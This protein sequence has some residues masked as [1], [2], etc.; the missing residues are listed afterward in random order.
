MTEKEL[1]KKVLIEIDKVKTA[2]LLLEE[3]NHYA[4]KA[5]NDWVK[6]N[7]PLYDK[8][9]QATDDLQVLKGIVT[10]D[11][12]TTTPTLTATMRRN[13][14]TST[15]VVVVGQRT[16]DGVT[17]QM[18]DDYYHLLKANIEF[19]AKQS[20]KCYSPTKNTVRTCHRLTDDKSIETNVYL[21]PDYN[22]NYIYIYNNNTIPVYPGSSTINRD[23][24]PSFE[25]RSGYVEDMF[26]YKKID[27]RYLKYPKMLN[28]TE[29][30]LDAAGDTSNVIE[31]P[32]YICDQIL[33]ILVAYVM[34]RNS[35][36]RT[37]NTYQISQTDNIQQQ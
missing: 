18:P 8:N 4:N 15:D 27:I 37:A 19:R 6:R 2:N 12:L 14:D 17:F 21:R 9:Q 24:Q 28:L 29:V 20:F 25:I 30:Q 11:I 23:R 33:K 1:Y 13:L 3:H 5:M 31:F 10:Y 35:D 7:Y 22:N 16:S 26:D 32:D 36:Q 34:E